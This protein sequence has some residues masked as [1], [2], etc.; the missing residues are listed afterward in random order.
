MSYRALGSTASAY[1]DTMSDYYKQQ[2]MAEATRQNSKLAESATKELG[3]SAKY[4]GPLKQAEAEAFEELLQSG[5]SGKMPTAAQFAPIASKLGASMATVG[6]TAACAAAGP[7]AP[8]CGAMAGYIANQIGAA[9]FGTDSGGCSLKVNGICYSEWISKVYARQLALCPPGDNDCRA[10]VKAIQDAWSKGFQLNYQAWINWQNR[11]QSVVVGKNNVPSDCYLQCPQ[12]SLKTLPCV[13]NE[14]NMGR[15]PVGPSLNVSDITLL[16]QSVAAEILKSKYA[17]E[18]KFVQT[19]ESQTAVLDKSIVPQCPSSGC[20]KQARGI[21][22]EGILEASLQLRTG[23]SQAAAQKRLDSALLQASGAVEQA[24]RLQAME[25][26]YSKDVAARNVQT[27]QTSE[28][29][30]GTRK[31]I[32]AVAAVAAVAAVGFAIYKRRR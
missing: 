30:D 29:S 21:I 8:L 2:A 5:S 14:I 31:A 1:V 24:R 23:G 16:D 28:S 9:I 27:A 10:K 6:G 20:V 22:S 4:A 3:I 19:V 18:R 32:L 26:S 7:V 15:G 13:F 25:T 17:A 12:N 11:C